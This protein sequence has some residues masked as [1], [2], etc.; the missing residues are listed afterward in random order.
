MEEPAKITQS[1]TARLN[2]L[3][4]DYLQ[5]TCRRIDMLF[6]CLALLQFV[7]ILTIRAENA[8]GI[9]PG[10]PAH[11]IHLATIALAAVLALFPIAF[12][13]MRPGR[14]ETR[15]VVAV[16]QVMFS[17]LFFHITKGSVASQLHL[18]V[19]IALL[20]VY[21]DFRVLFT[22]AIIASVG[23][24]GR[25]FF[26]P[27]IPAEILHAGAL[28]FA[29]HIALTLVECSGLAWVV[30]N[31][32]KQ[33]QVSLHRQAMWEITNEHLPTTA[34]KL[35]ASEA[36]FRSLS[37]SSPIGIFQ[38]DNQ[39]RCTYV[40]QRW[41]TITGMDAEA[42]LG[43]GWMSVIH[44]EDCQSFGTKW[45]AAL[46]RGKEFSAE[47]RV[48][49]PKG[50]SRWV[51]C[52][53]TALHDEDEDITGYVGTMEDIT[54][55]K[56]AEVEMQRAMEAAEATSRS[57]SEFLANMSH[58]IRTPMT[59]ILGYAELLLRQNLEE[60]E[61]LNCLTT[62]RRNG[63]HLLNVI[64]DILDIS[65]IE[66]GKMTVERIGCSPG[67]ILADIGMLMR[68]RAWEKGLGFELQ[69]AGPIPA[70]IQSDPTRLRQVLMNLVGNAIKF[71]QSGGI[72]MVAS[73]DSKDTSDPLLKV[74]VVDTGIGL[75]IEQRMRLLKPFTQADTSTTRKFGGTGLGL[76][77]SMKLSEMLGGGIAIKS[78]PGKGSAFTVSVK[79]GPLFGV[80]MYRSPE[81][82]P[83]A[84]P[85]AVPVENIKLKGRVLLAED[86]VDNQDLI[87]FHLRDA[88]L[89]VEVVPD[90]LQAY[91]AAVKSM[92]IGVPFDVILM[93][94][95]MPE[96]DGYTAT[97]RLRNDGYVRPIV[98]LT[99]HAMGGDKQK[100]IA[101]GCSDYV[102]KPIEWDR[103]LTML[104]Q[105]LQKMGVVSTGEGREYSSSTY[106]EIP[107]AETTEADVGALESQVNGDVP[108]RTHEDRIVSSL[109]GIGKM[110]P[111]VERFIARLPE[112]VKEM[113]MAVES[114][115]LDQLSVLAHQ[116]KGA[117]TGYGFPTLTDSAKNLEMLAKAK[118]DIDAI[119]KQFDELR[120]LCARAD[121]G[122]SSDK[123][124]AG[125]SV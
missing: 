1:V 63:Q 81:E 118:V 8:V 25:A 18:F 17:W 51:R 44:P 49:T 101:A 91:E 104:Q 99:A 15:H 70:M 88:G 50:A 98:A 123:T 32:Q 95:Q 85:A 54:E 110:A 90:G 36:R 113:K 73:V 89:E 71:T 26:G 66:A 77:I 94:M 22:A 83:D 12:G 56:Q 100:C 47:Y 76:A 62:I 29:E 87:S 30:R 79:T 106:T 67:Q 84:T 80:A 82:A 116:L 72:K 75:T 117:A 11:T 61:R 34:V 52:R 78:T 6:A 14:V 97:R 9:I 124:T 92:R 112:R 55:A 114:N 20:A 43:S 48:L 23:D 120:D 64:N 86:G 40:N 16:S 2:E 59:A 103:L 33:V 41:E 108:H 39:S 125:T 42:S 21:G 53:A 46:S 109:A 5:Q 37:M 58:E 10:L 96:M 93:D 28:G 3:T 111:L 19:S 13:A 119:G 68:G 7:A 4:R 122:T 60:T 115:Q 24:F 27:V 121:A 107:V 38:T 102:T 69:F 105:F 45:S 57:K 65:K 31:D 74:E 35:K